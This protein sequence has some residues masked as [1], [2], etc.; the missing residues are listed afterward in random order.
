MHKGDTS[1]HTCVSST[2]NLEP[3]H[4]QRTLWTRRVIS[5][6]S[7][8]LPFHSV[9]W[10][11]DST[12]QQFPFLR[13][14]GIVGKNP[15]FFCLRLFNGT[16]L[17][18][19]RWQDY[20]SMD[21]TDNHVNIRFISKRGPTSASWT[22]PGILTNTWC[23]SSRQSGLELSYNFQCLPEWD[24]I[25]FICKRHDTFAVF[26]WHGKQ[27][28]K[29]IPYPHTEFRG[30]LLKYEVWVLLW[31]SGWFIRADVMTKSNVV[32]RKMDG[33]TMGK[34][35]DDQCIWEAWI[36]RSEH[37]RVTAHLGYP[38]VRVKQWG[39]LY[40][41]H[42]MCLPVPLRHSFRDLFDAS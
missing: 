23:L 42:D 31:Y 11:A 29:Y 14:P 4:Q 2:H 10:F 12:W 37:Y 35:G 36:N 18:F 28:L 25:I 9:F 15:F 34:V 16:L 7:S 17:Y 32:K 6:K 27:E 20:H 19:I 40:R 8:F 33:W 3:S 38:G 13:C 1:Q 30:E 41:W 22:S 26:L 39:Q 24:E 5:N 21:M